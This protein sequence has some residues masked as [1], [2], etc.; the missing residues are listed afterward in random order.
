MRRIRAARR[1]PASASLSLLVLPLLL[2]LL[3]GCGLISQPGLLFGGKGVVEPRIADALNG[4]RP[5]AVDLLVVYDDGLQKEL[6]GLTAADWFAKRKT[7]LSVVP[8]PKLDHWGWEWVPGQQ[9]EPQR[10]DYR[11]G[12]LSSIVFVSYASPGEHRAQLKANRSFRLWL[13]ERDFRVEVL[14]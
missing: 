2:V 12:A 6:L 7:Y 1:V 13:D 3:T 11:M 10:F 4:D 5:V 8:D 14:Y 9:V